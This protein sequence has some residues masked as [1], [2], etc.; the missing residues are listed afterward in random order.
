[1]D[2]GVIVP[3]SGPQPRALYAGGVVNLGR[4]W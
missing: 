1:V 2:A 4:A 3:I